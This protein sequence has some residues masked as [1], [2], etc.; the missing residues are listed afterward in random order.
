MHETIVSHTK[1]FRE[2]SENRKN[3]IA[4]LP[5]PL[6]SIGKQALT[7][8]FIH[9]E[10]CTISYEFGK[11]INMIKKN[12]IPFIPGHIWPLFHIDIH[13]RV[14]KVELFGLFHRWKFDGSQIT[15]SLLLLSSTFGRCFQVLD[16]LCRVSSYHYVGWYILGNDSSSCNDRSRIWKHIE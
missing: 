4:L 3:S 8:K 2:I 12:F 1:A 5:V 15:S 13:K 16:D 10:M 11:V 14:T 9:A 6:P 7:S